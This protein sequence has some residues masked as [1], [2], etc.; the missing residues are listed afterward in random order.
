MLICSL[1]C[2]SF[3]EITSNFKDNIDNHD[4]VGDDNNDNDDNGDD[5]EITAIITATTLVMI[6]IIVIAIVAIKNTI[7]PFKLRIIRFF[8]TLKDTIATNI[9]QRLS[10]TEG[11][12][13]A[14]VLGMS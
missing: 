11:H 8:Y 13:S 3:S 10:P 4:N 7:T 2:T 5:K 1:I 6:I 9:P 14:S 12:R